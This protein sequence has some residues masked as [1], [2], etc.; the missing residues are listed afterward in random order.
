MNERDNQANWILNKSFCKLSPKFTQVIMVMSLLNL[1]VWS[2]RSPAHGYFRLTEGSQD[3]DKYDFFHR[4]FL[5]YSLSPCKPKYH[6]NI[7]QLMNTAFK[8]TVS[9][10]NF[11][12]PEERW[13]A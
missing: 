1:P 12:I 9:K 11:W 8:T 2:D 13:E 10:N 3:S 4:K 7:A 5:W 6:L